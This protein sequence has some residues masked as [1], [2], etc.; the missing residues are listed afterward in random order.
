MYLPL[1]CTS[2]RTYIEFHQKHSYEV[3][4][5]IFQ[6]AIIPTDPYKIEYR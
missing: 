5:E 3:K 2:K 1:L 4:N 6:G